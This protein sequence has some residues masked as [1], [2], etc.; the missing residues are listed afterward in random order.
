MLVENKILR[1]WL[2]KNSDNIISYWNNKLAYPNFTIAF[3]GKG[4]SE[5][6]VIAEL[7]RPWCGEVIPIYKVKLYN[8]IDFDENTEPVVSIDQT[9]LQSVIALCNKAVYH[10]V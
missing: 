5:Y 3:R 6:F 1:S 4:G 10:G 9:R 2:D 8:T 7:I